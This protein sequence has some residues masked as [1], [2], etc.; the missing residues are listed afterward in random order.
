[1][2]LSTRAK[3]ISK[4]YGSPSKEQ[5]GRMFRILSHN[6]LFGIRRDDI[7]KSLAERFQKGESLQTIFNSMPFFNYQNKANALTLSRM[8]TH[9]DAWAVRFSEIIMLDRQDALKALSYWEPIDQIG[10]VILFLFTYGYSQSALYK[11][12]KLV[13]AGMVVSEARSLTSSAYTFG[14]GS[15]VYTIGGNL[16]RTLFSRRMTTLNTLSLFILMISIPAGLWIDPPKASSNYTVGVYSDHL[17]RAISL[18]VGWFVP[19]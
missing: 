8:V 12:L 17:G 6:Y 18:L 3:A 4:E 7:V 13:L 9:T 11:L 2:S 16:L 15:I 10:I 14:T 1:M 19:V 5:V